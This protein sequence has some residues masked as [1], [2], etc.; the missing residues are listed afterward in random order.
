[1]TGSG[2]TIGGASVSGFLDV[3][4]RTGSW[5]LERRLLVRPFPQ[6]LHGEEPDVNQWTELRKDMARM[7]GT[8]VIIGG[9]RLQTGGLV[10][11]DGVHEELS[12]AQVDNLEEKGTGGGI[13]GYKRR[14]GVA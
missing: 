1:V 4:Q 10:P 5:D 11:S 3:L 13:A 14:D 9:A 7:A 2:S 8:I 6:A 12:L